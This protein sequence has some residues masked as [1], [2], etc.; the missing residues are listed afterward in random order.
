MTYNSGVRNPQVDYVLCRRCNH[1]EVTDC[2]V[3]GGR[4]EC[5]EKLMNEENESARRVEEAIVLGQEVV[6]IS[7]GEGGLQLAVSLRTNLLINRSINIFGLT[8]SYVDCYSLSY[9]CIL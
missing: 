6:V 1:K 3:M 5:S 7:K 8:Y 2:N 4:A 9:I